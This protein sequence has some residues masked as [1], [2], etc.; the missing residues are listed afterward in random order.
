[1]FNEADVEL[2][3]PEHSHGDQWGVV[4]DGRIDLTIDEI[5]HTFG[6]GDT[7]F[8]PAGSPHSARIYPGFR[9]IDFFADRDRYRARSRGAK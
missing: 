7:Y 2:A 5:P 8:I 1:M 9:A 4:L 6:R 3:V